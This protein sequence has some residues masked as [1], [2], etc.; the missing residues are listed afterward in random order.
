MTT[1]AAHHPVRARISGWPHEHDVAHL[2]LLDHHMIPDGDDIARW[3]E[4]GRETG[5]RTIRT[6]AM[7]PNA[8][9]PFVEAGFTVIDTLRLLE[10]DLSAAT[11]ATISGRAARTAMRTTRVRRSQLSDAADV[12]RRSFVPPWSNDTAALEDILDATPQHR[13]RGI[14]LDGTLVAFAISGRAGSAG[15]V[16]RLAVDPSVRRRGMAN[17]LLTDALTWMRRR[18]VTTVLVNTATDNVAATE[19]YRAAGFI[20]RNEPLTIFERSLLKP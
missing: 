6:G 16:Q 10:L 4:L 7:F 15:Y 20:D 19:L 1:A 8:A 9:P 13:A 5:A 17:V 2:V 3:L 18:R 14:R 12:D 11:R